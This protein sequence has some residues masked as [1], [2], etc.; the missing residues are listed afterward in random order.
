MHCIQRIV[1]SLL[2][3]FLAVPAALMAQRTTATISGTVTDQSSA[4]VP[5]P[6]V[7]A[8]EK[9]TGASSQAQANS[10]GFYVLSGLLPG[11]YRLRVEK[12]GFQAYVQEGIIVQVNRPVSINVTL[13]VGAATQTVNVAGEAQQV[14][15]RSQTLSYEVTTQMVTELLA[16][17]RPSFPILDSSCLPL[18]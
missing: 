4:M 8:V 3:A 14:N 9:S 5:A 13:Q 6:Q 1:C 7:T 18:R 2:I 11:E 16:L 17:G 15:L 12:D 10:E